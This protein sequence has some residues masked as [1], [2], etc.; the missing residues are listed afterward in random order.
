MFS[1]ERVNEILDPIKAGISSQH[2]RLLDSQRRI[3]TIEFV[4][5]LVN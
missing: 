5:W 4:N 3:C 2:D 1:C